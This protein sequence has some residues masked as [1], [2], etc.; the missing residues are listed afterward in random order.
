MDFL[1]KSRMSS[2]RVGLTVSGAVVATCLSSVDTPVDL[3]V[4]C[5]FVDE[6]LLM[7]IVDSFV[8]CC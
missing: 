4:V 2:L 1:Q 3:H 8:D 6:M 5:V 7:L